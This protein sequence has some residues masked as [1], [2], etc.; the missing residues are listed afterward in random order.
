[1]KYFNFFFSLILLFGFTNR[2]LSASKDLLNFVPEDAVF[3]L[4]I[5]DLNQF[6]EE[7]EAGPLGAFTRSKAWEKGRE[8]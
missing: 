6:T 8:W 1:M 3:L 7:I 5:D 4:E 2:V